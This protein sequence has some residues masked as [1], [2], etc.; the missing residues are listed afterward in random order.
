M[1]CTVG[2]DIYKIVLYDY[3]ANIAVDRKPEHC[4]AGDED[5]SSTVFCLGEKT[6]CAKAFPSVVEQPRD[7]FRV[8]NLQNGFHTA[9]DFHTAVWQTPRSLCADTPPPCVPRGQMPW[10]RPVAI[11]CPAAVP[12]TEGTVWGPNP[13]AP[14]EQHRSGLTENR[15]AS[16]QFAQYRLQ[17]AWGFQIN[18]SILEF[19]LSSKTDTAVSIEFLGEKYTKRA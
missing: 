5:I 4:N 15:W 12:A 1:K 7:T 18:C 16:A 14:G 11:V 13:R 8:G 2:M 19:P 17:R 9:K 3:E 6:K 10:P